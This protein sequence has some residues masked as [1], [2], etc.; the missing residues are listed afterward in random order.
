MTTKGFTSP[1]SFKK[2][3]S[4]LRVHRSKQVILL[5]SDLRKHWKLKEEK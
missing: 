4:S 1:V 3:L 2:N 5:P